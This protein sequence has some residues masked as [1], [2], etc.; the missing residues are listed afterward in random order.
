MCITPCFLFC[1]CNA[2]NKVP[3]VYHFGNNVRFLLV[4]QSKHSSANPRRVCS[5]RRVSDL[6]VGKREISSCM[7]LLNYAIGYS[8]TLFQGLATAA[9]Y[10]PVRGPGSSCLSKKSSG[11]CVLPWGSGTKSVSSIVLVANGVS[12][13]VCRFLFSAKSRCHITSFS[14]HDTSFCN[15]RSGC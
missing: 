7:A 2:I 12:F 4:I 15:H 8:L 14:D 6:K 10:D 11:K 3:P 5:K 13:A 9:G 1:F